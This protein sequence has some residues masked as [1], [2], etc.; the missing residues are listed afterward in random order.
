MK[1]GLFLYGTICFLLGTLIGGSGVVYAAY[2]TAERCNQSIF[3][4]G[5]KL[6]LEAY[7]IEGSNYVKLR[8]V[9]KA[10]DFNVYYDGDVR[11]ERN[12]PYT[13]T[14]PEIGNIAQT[15]AEPNINASVHAKL[16]PRD[17]RRAASDDYQA[18]TVR[19]HFAD[20]DAGIELRLGS[21]R[22]HG[23]LAGLHS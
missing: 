12:K 17:V 23:K 6:E 13:G 8:D 16:Y 11:V 2:I 1:R 15:T 10:L 20:D 22:G 21:H 18:G 5:T 4:D 19:P 14:P 3:L 9:G 7:T